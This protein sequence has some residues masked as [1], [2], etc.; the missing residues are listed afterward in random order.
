[1]TAVARYRRELSVAAAFGLLLLILAAFGATQAGWLRHTSLA[2][3]MPNTA[4]SAILAAFAIAW[5]Q[6]GFVLLE[7]TWAAISLVGTIRILC[8]AISSRRSWRKGLTCG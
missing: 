3:L 6:W 1:M 5:H 8:R 7:G 4:G 2:Y